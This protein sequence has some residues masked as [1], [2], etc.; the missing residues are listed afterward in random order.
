MLDFRPE[1]EYLFADNFSD[2]LMQQREAVSL[3]LSSNNRPIKLNKG[4]VGSKQL[5]SPPCLIVPFS[6]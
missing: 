6:N 2:K 5:A 3:L 4:L 1:L